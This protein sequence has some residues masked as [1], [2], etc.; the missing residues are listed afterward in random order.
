MMRCKS[1]LFVFTL[2]ILSFSLAMIPVGRTAKAANL[3]STVSVGP[4]PEG[5][6]G[7]IGTTNFIFRLDRTGDLSGQCTVFFETRDGTAFAPEDYTT[8][9]SSAFFSANQNFFNIPVSVTGELYAEG[10]E[11]FFFHITGADGCTVGNDTGTAVIYND[12]TPPP[13]GFFFIGVEGDIAGGVPDAALRVNDLVIM[14]R[15]ALGIDAPP[16]GWYF[17]KADIN[18]DCGDGQINSADVVVLRQWIL[19]G[20]ARRNNCGPF[21]PQ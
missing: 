10:D 21:Q 3:A 4:S 13:P 8:L 15:F 12:E 9:S 7:N 17:Q 11:T 5:A 6:E 16:N 20:T 14:R 18:G 2:G 1:A 19:L